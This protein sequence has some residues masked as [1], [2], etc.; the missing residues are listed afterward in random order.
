MRRP[1]SDIFTNDR[2]KIGRKFITD[3][4]VAE[5]VEIVWTSPRDSDLQIADVKLISEKI[6][7]T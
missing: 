3:G 7:P 4:T 6:K 1:Y 2:P 5:I